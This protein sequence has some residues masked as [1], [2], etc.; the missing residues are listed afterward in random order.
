M[1]EQ[2]LFFYQWNPPSDTSHIYNYTTIVFD[3]HLNFI[4]EA[5][6]CGEPAY[7]IK[8]YIYIS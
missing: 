1:R 7:E 5:D 8:V 3:S 6:G 4:K 2:F